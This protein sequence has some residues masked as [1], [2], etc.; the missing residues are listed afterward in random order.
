VSLS[1]K[2]KPDVLLRGDKEVS[3]IVEGRESGQRCCL[4]PYSKYPETSKSESHFLDQ[5]AQR[6]GAKFV[7]VP[8]FLQK[9]ALKSL[10]T[11][12]LRDSTTTYQVWLR[13]CFLDANNNLSIYLFF[14]KAI[15]SF[16]NQCNSIDGTYT[17]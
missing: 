2:K 4:I 9:E 8:L 5:L 15:T 13:C 7:F 11:K 6:F 16:H 1:K 14:A 10:E 17:R 3:E 12:Q